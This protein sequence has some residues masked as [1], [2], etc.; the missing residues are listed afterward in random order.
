MH[1]KVASFIAVVLVALAGCA[2]TGVIQSGSDR[3]MVS[4]T[5]LKVGFGPPTAAH[6]A[7][8]QEADDFCAK[9]NKKV[10][11]VNANIT[12]PAL[13]RPGSATL[14]FRCITK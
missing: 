7:I 14:E 6:A 1:E 4:K 3:Y 10:E 13:G 12:H 2:S 5:S 9:Q 8:S 11:V